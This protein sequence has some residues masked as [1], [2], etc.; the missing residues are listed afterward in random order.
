MRN[1]AEI[2]GGAGK[3]SVRVRAISKVISGNLAVHVVEEYI[4][5]GGG[6]NKSPSMVLATNI[7]LLQDD[8]WQMVEHHA[9]LPGVDLEENRRKSALHCCALIAGR[10]QYFA[11]F[12]AL[13]ERFC[14]VWRSLYV[15]CGFP[16][17]WGHLQCCI[18][19]R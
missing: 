17:M 10:W 15:H 9:S 14:L 2:F 6:P 18:V 3:P 13:Q 19:R 8:A 7:F 16:A 1:W 5:P 4:T 11:A 12:T